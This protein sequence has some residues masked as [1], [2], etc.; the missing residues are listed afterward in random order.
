MSNT[1]IALKT[2]NGKTVFSGL[3]PNHGMCLEAAVRQNTS[4]DYIDISGL[5]L[6]NC[7]LDGASLRHA[8]LRGCDLTSANLSECDMRHCL[9]DDARLVDA[10]LTESRMDYASLRRTQLQAA[11]MQR[12]SLFKAT[13]TTQAARHVDWPSLCPRWPVYLET[14]GRNNTLIGCVK[15]SVI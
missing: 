6:R 10:C 15:V 11:M 9:L 14:E 5:V 1:Y 3:F 12:V 2:R 13:L 4:L 7:T 8:D